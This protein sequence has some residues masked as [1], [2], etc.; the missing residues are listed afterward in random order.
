[1]KATTKPIIKK[2]KKEYRGYQVIYKDNR[3]VEAKY[4]LTLQEKR[5]LLFSLSKITADEFGVK[6]IVFSTKELAKMCGIEGNS[7]HENLKKTTAKLMSRVFVVKNLD[8]Q[9]YSQFNWVNRSTYHEKK[10][11]VEI[12]F[13][14]DLSQFFIDLK[15][16]FTVIPLSQTLGLR[17]MYSI[18]MYELLKQYENIRCRDFNVC[19]LKETLGISTEKMKKYND[20]KRDVLEIAQRELLEKTDIRFEFEEIKTARS[21][22]SIEFKIYSNNQNLI[23]SEEHR[24]KKIEDEMMGI[25][26]KTYL[27]KISVSEPTIR[28]YLSEHSHDQIKKA[29]SYVEHQHESLIEKQKDKEKRTKTTNT[30]KGILNKKAY[31][32]KALK[33][34]WGMKC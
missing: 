20:F 5:L 19:E 10:G 8:K 34:G 1:M 4:D 9:T 30:Q 29:I 26:E 12:Q 24:A 7:T 13:N 33:E 11:I 17:S 21:V 14:R 27:R 16:K 25:D 28:K 31:L 15:E 18:R 6:P 22:T 32:R 2:K 23:S 3:L